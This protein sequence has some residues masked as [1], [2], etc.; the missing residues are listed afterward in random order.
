MLVT[1]AKQ[2][3]MISRL[4]WDIAEDRGQTTIPDYSFTFFFNDPDRIVLLEGQKFYN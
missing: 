2:I 3:L 1:C 4:R